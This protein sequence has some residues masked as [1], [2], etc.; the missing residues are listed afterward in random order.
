MPGSGTSSI[1]T[2]SCRNSCSS[3]G[4]SSSAA[5]GGFCSVILAPNPRSPAQDLH[6]PLA[7]A[8]VTL[9]AVPELPDVEHYR[10]FFRDHA[11]GKRVLSVWADPT[12]VRNATA[13][14]LAGALIGHRFEDPARKGKW[15][16]CSTDG[17]VLL[18]HFG[19]TGDL[20]WSGDEP[21]R[22]RHDRLALAF[23]EGGELRYRNMRKLGGVWLAHDQGELDGLIGSLGPD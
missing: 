7:V 6:G 10:R 13:E 18:L 11:A 8:T 22:H 23:V 12:I 15:L 1:S 20:V 2:A 21:L 19:M 4:E 5:S 14:A 17:P 3:D 16:M 9:P